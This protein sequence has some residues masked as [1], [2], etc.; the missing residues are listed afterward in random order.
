MERRVRSPRDGM[1]LRETDPNNQ[2][3]ISLCK[4]PQL[5]FE[6]IIVGRLDILYRHA[7]LCLGPHRAFERR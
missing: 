4:R 5:R 1:S 6:R 3:V 7:Q 2:I